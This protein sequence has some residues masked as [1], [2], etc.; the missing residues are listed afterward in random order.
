MVFIG[1]VFQIINAAIPNH[2]LLKSDYKVSDMQF[3]GVSYIY[4]S[5]RDLII[6]R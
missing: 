6:I 2:A 5:L 1:C 4:I 3:Q